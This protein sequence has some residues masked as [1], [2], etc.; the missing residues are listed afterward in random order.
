[1]ATE[2]EAARPSKTRKTGIS[3]FGELREHKMRVRAVA[4]SPDGRML[5]T[6]SED[7]TVGFLD[8]SEGGFTSV[9]TSYYSKVNAVEWS[10]DGSKV[11]ATTLDGE[12]HLIDPRTKRSQM[13]IETEGAIYPKAFG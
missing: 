10:P 11:L 6:G 1:M 13:L 9:I 3:P 12:V 8:L 2:T 7:E 4:W 5:A